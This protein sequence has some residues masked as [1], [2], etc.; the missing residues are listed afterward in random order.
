MPRECAHTTD[1]KFAKS[2]SPFSE[3]IIYIGIH[4]HTLK[5]L[6]TKSF[7]VYLPHISTGRFNY[8]IWFWDESGCIT[9]EYNGDYSDDAKT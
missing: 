9:V 2:K 4:M 8:K 1:W 6:A 7:N 3:L 5:I